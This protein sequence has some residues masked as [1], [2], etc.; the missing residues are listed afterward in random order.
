MFTFEVKSLLILTPPFFVCCEFLT[1]WIQNLCLVLLLS[2]RNPLCSHDTIYSRLT[3]TLEYSQAS[4]DIHILGQPCVGNPAA[5][6]GAMS[7]CAAY[8]MRVV[9]AVKGELGRK[10]NKPLIFSSV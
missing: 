8:Y 4:L 7:H 10:L 1:F 6:E 2:Y 9:T 3:K 5:N